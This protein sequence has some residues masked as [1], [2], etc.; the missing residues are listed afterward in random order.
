MGAPVQ[1]VLSAPV[2]WRE[3]RQH[4]WMFG[5]TAIP[6]MDLFFEKENSSWSHLGIR[7]AG[8]WILRSHY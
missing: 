4:G 6:E 8:K 1:D 3:P 5:V 2:T 7:N